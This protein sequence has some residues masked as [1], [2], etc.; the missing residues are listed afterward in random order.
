[1]QPIKKP[2]QLP[3][4]KSGMGL[5]HSKVGLLPSMAYGKLITTKVTKVKHA[6]ATVVSCLR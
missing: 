5:E 6:L 3:Q 1:M 4:I 2:K